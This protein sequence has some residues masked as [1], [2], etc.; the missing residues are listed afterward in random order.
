[1]V[2]RS[3]FAESSK[4]TYLRGLQSNSNGRLA[5]HIRST[6]RIS[7]TEKSGMNIFKSS[8]VNFKFTMYYPDRFQSYITFPKTYTH[9][10]CNAHANGGKQD[11]KALQLVPELRILPICEIILIRVLKPFQSAT[12]ITLLVIPKAHVS[13]YNNECGSGDGGNKNGNETRSIYGMV[14]RL[15]QERPDKIT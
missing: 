12:L 8:Y 6:D 14:L 10:I 9:S 2:W 13:V 11:A 15:E 7:L 4:S 1:M 5:S 3:W